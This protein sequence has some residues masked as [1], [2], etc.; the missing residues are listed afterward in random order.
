MKINIVEVNYFC[1]HLPRYS[2]SQVPAV[3]GARGQL[4]AHA[5]VSADTNASGFAR[6]MILLIALEQI[7]MALKLRQKT[8]QMKSVMV[9]KLL[10]VRLNFS[11]SL[12]KCRL[13]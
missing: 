1:S 12:T 3:A 2:L 4:S 10:S 11:V 5:T 7:I 13:N 9:I 6:H 8:V